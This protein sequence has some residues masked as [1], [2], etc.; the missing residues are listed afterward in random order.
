MR[1]ATVEWLKSAYPSELG[2]L[3]SGKPTLAD[4]KE[5]YEFAK[6]IHEQVSDMA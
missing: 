5:F 4:V 3:P 2:L 6:R 1:K